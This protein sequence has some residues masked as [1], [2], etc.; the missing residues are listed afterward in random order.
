VTAGENHIYFWNLE[1]KMLKSKPGKW[2]LVDIEDLTVTEIAF[3][4]KICFT[5]SKQGHLITWIKKRAQQPL[6][7]HNSEISVLYTHESYL[8][9]GCRAGKVIV[10]SFSNNNL[11]KVSEIMNFTNLA[12]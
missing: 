5:G 3:A 4:K 1:G 8:Y 6:L 11:N 2:G 12:K 10:W 7:A 9:S